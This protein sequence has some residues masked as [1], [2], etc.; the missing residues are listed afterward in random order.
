MLK[1]DTT[2]A[3]GAISRL[4]KK[5]KSTSS[6]DVQ[7]KSMGSSSS[8]VGTSQSAGEIESLSQLMQIQEVGERH[9]NSKQAKVSGEAILLSLEKLQNEILVGAIS[10]QSLD[11]IVSMT[12]TLPSQISDPNLKQV[13][14]EI[15]QRAM[16]EIAKIEMGT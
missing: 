1:I 3:Y 5:G 15:K 10:R 7:G 9:S 11:H 4:K 8:A 12:Q 16:I 13:I 2:R 6:F 14:A